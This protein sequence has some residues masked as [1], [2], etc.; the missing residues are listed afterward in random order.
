MDA[1]KIKTTLP[2]TVRAVTAPGQERP[3]YKPTPSIKGTFTLADVAD[4]A[5]VNGY[6][7]GAIKPEAISAHTSA[8]FEQSYR[9]FAKGHNVNFGGFLLGKLVLTGLLGS[10]RRLTEANEVKVSFSGGPNF[11][12]DT[13]AFSFA[14]TGGAIL[15]ASFDDLQAADLESSGEVRFGPGATVTAKGRTLANVTKDNLRVLRLDPETGA[16]LETAQIASEAKFDTAHGLFVAFPGG[17]ALESETT[18]AEW[19]LANCRLVVGTVGT[20]GEFY[21]MGKPAKFNFLKGL[22][23]VTTVSQEGVEE[24]NTVVFLN[25]DD[26][27]TISG[28]NLGDV[29]ASMLQTVIRDKTT[30]EEIARSGLDVTG[31]FTATDTAITLPGGLVPAVRDISDGDHCHNRAFLV[32][33]LADGTVYEFEFTYKE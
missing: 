18:Q 24:E 7:T 19:L 4:Y 14:R 20:D 1:R 2:Y 17:L 25:I 32:I 28:Y 9:E 5:K 6:L 3:S 31:G 15:G 10:D 11:A 27:V 12:L 23:R 13:A 16:V 22:P 26:P 30:G 29:T 33:T 21:P 8:V